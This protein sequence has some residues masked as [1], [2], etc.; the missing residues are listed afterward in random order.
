MPDDGLHSGARCEVAKMRVLVADDHSGMRV[1]L[2]T[3]IE[4]FAELTVVA[5]ASDGLEA[6]QQ[7]R[8][9]QPDI[10]TLDWRSRHRGRSWLRR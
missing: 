1:G 2:A 5:E 6:L 10:M 9:L 3:I 7:F 8:S 4:D